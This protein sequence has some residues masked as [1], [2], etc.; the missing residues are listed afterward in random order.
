M[1]HEVTKEDTFE[2]A[3]RLVKLGYNPLVLSF[4]SATNPGGGWRGKQI[5]T[6]EESL[7]RRS[8]LGTELEKK[9]YPIPDLGHHYIKNVIITKDQNMNPIDH[10]KCSVIACE[11][12]GICERSQKYLETKVEIMYQV[13]ESNNHN[14]IVLGAIGCGAF[15]ESDDDAEILANVMKKIANKH[16]KIKTVYAIFRGKQNYDVFNRVMNC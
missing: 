14:T 11:L 8:N 6:Q 15:K 5:G 1:H 12:S 16:N 10:I 7:C 3:I 2:C 4:S 9:R 13:A